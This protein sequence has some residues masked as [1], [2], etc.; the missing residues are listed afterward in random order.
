MQGNKTGALKVDG[1][2]VSLA[3]LSAEM[4][5]KIETLERLK[6]EEERQRNYAQLER[7]RILCRPSWLQYSSVV[8]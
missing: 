5:K 2:G 7:V 3:P 6:D 1:D 8:G 4:V